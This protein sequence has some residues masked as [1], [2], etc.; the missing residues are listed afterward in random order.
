[1]RQASSGS[2]TRRLDV[3]GTTSWGQSGASGRG[4]CTASPRPVRPAVSDANVTAWP[5]DVGGRRLATD[6]RPATDS[7]SGSEH[8]SPRLRGVH[9]LK[10]VLGRVG[11]DARPLRG[12]HHSSS[13]DTIAQATTTASSKPSTTR[14]ATGVTARYGFSSAPAM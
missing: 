4:E 1:M 10:L 6:A 14:D 9:L 11:P 8:R 2:S 13:V 5:T 3:A 12:V 7:D